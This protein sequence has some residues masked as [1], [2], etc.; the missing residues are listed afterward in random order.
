MGENE[1]M[2]AFYRLL[3]RLFYSV[4]QVDGVI[5]EEEFKAV[6]AAVREEWLDF[7]ETFDAF[8]SDSAFQIEF[9]FDFLYEN[10]RKVEN[11]LHEL[12]EAKR[13]NPSLFTENLKKRIINSC[14]K[15]A[16]AVAGTNKSELVFLS[17]LEQALK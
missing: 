15:I 4:A 3:G 2:L 6:K 12:K 7:D 8:G 10:D 13:M 16:T 9:V 1:K 11:V 14:A 5:R 17:K